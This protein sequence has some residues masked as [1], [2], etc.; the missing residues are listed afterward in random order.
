MPVHDEDERV[1]A[2]GEVPPQGPDFV[3]PAH[4]PAAQP[5]LLNLQGLD[6]EADR[7]DGRDHVSGISSQKPIE[8]SRL[9]SCMKF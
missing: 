5:G 6:I 1:H 3:A 2:R 7:G 9:T 8:K 4:V